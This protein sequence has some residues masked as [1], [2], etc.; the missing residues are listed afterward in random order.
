[1]TTSFEC[2]D[3]GKRFK[4][5]EGDHRER[6]AEDHTVPEGTFEIIVCP[7]CGCENLRLIKEIE[8]EEVEES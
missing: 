3:C 8:A 5:N 6:N 4:K 2:A 7:R 1:M